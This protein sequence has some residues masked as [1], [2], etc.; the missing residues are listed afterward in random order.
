MILLAML[1]GSDYTEGVEGVG[2]VTALE[3]MAE[4]EGEGLARL[5]SFK[6]WWDKV[7]SEF[8]KDYGMPIG[9]KVREKLRKLKLSPGFPSEAVMEAYVHPRV[10]E[11]GEKFSWSVPN[12]VAV[13]DFAKERFGWDKIQIDEILKPVIRSLQKNSSQGR[14]D[15]YFTS[16]RVNLPDKGLQ[17]SK[18]VE[19]AL[20]KFRGLPSPKKDSPKKFQRPKPA[21]K[22]KNGKKAASTTATGSKAASGSAESV[23]SE[24]TSPALGPSREVSLIAKSC[25]FV[26]APS[27]DDIILQR[28]EREKKARETKARAVEIFKKSQETRQKRTKKR[29]KRPARVQLK[30]HELSSEED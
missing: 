13:R 10:D 27:A 29:F 1:T 22:L 24:T 12:L 15:S 3:I 4:F 25:G 8:G 6:A 11:S 7:Q 30:N 20:R 23:G 26:V 5:K 18:R 19:E 14:I 16:Y 21:P 9:N 17:S 28:E 2:P